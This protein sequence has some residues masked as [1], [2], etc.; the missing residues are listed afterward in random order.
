MK[1]YLVFVAILAGVSLLSPSS[2]IAAGPKIGGCSVFPAD[3]VWNTPIDTLPLDAS[4]TTYVNT[5]GANLGLKADFGAGL[6]DGGPIGIPFVTVSGTQTKYP[7]TFDYDDESD[8]GPYAMPLNAP[9]EGGSQSDGDRHVLSI[10]TTNCILYELYSAYPGSNRW[11][12]GSGA[13]YDLNGYALRP[14]DLD[15]RR[16]RRP[17]DLPRPRAL[18]R[19]RRGRDQHTP[20]ASPCP[21]RATPTSGP[22]AT[23]PRASPAPSTR[24][25]A[26]A[27]ASRPTSISA[28]SRRPTR[29]SCGRS[30]PT[31]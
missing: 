6:W 12:A 10:D 3:H 19:D 9:I 20:S 27:S 22:P 4:S 14:D 16:R 15:L 24:P 23:R 31:A 17:A 26:S 30:R 18:R 2:A 8:P 29:S 28:A 5:I 1:R 11:D 13:I 7:V 25:W 21:R